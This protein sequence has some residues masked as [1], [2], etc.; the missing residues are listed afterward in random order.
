[1]ELAKK[2]PRKT[3]NNNQFTAVIRRWNAKISDEIMLYGQYNLKKE[4]NGQNS[5]ELTGFFGL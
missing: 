3:E 1:L 5:V 4:N 2:K